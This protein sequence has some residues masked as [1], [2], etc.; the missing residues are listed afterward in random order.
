MDTAHN[1]PTPTEADAR[2]F[3]AALNQGLLWDD[4][5]EMAA[6]DVDHIEGTDGGGYLLGGRYLVEHQLNGPYGRPGYRVEQTDEEAVERFANALAEL[7]ADEDTAEECANGDWQWTLE[8][9][10]TS[11]GLALD[12]VRD[13]E[14]GCPE[15]GFVVGGL[16]VVLGE[17]G[18]L[19]RWLSDDERGRWLA[20]RAERIGREHADDF[21]NDDPWALDEYDADEDDIECPCCGDASCGIC[22][23]CERE[24]ARGGMVTTSEAEALHAAL[25]SV[26]ADDGIS[27][28]AE[29][30]F[31]A[32]CVFEFIGDGYGLYVAPD[33]SV[34]VA[35]F[36]NERLLLAIEAGA[37]PLARLL[38]RLAELAGAGE[39]R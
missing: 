9:A 1:T 10:S 5:A 36:T 32:H 30:V 37:D 13:Y 14:H 39:M 29:R 25:A 6:I 12:F 19:L 24:L 34:E 7:L 18:Q 33:G 3:A 11:A 26:F 4:A 21:A 28:E 8:Q 17:D 27:S 15:A 23:Q 31:V 16:A 2:S 35:S 22:E 20:R 38:A